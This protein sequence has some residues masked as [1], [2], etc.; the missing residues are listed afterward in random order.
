[1]K[2]A[3]ANIGEAEASEL[4]FSLEKAGLAS[5]AELI[6]RQAEAFIDTLEVLLTK[7]R[8]EET[9]TVDDTEITED[10]GFLKEQLEKVKDACEDYDRKNAEAALMLLKDKEWKAETMFMLEEIHDA[11]FLHSDFEK[12]VEIIEAAG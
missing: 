4:A 3:L 5:E 10:T 6:S 12:V 7:L 8:P 11:L 9:I 1:M 2:S